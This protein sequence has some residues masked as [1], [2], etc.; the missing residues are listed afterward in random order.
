M[1]PHSSTTRIRSTHSIRSLSICGITVPLCRPGEW[2]LVDDDDEQVY[3]FTRTLTNADGTAER[4]LVAINLTGRH[5]ALPK[6][7][8]DLLA[9]GVSEDRIILST[10]DAIHSAKSLA[11]GELAGW[12]GVVVEL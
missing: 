7:V 8:A 3:A 2:A 1:P 4:M 11:N 12:E 6:P 5:A 9:D 10:Y